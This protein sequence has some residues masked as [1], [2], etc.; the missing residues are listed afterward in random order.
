MKVKEKRKGEKIDISKEEGG[1][2]QKKKELDKNKKKGNKKSKDKKLK[3]KGKNERRIGKKWKKKMQVH[4]KNILN[5]DMYNN[6]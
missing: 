3:I 2:N 5:S 4:L 6:K 1:I